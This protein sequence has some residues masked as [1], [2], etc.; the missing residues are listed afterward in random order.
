MEIKSY[1]SQDYTCKYPTQVRLV[2]RYATKA[3]LTHNGA[4]RIHL[5]LNI[6]N[7]NYNTIEQEKERLNIG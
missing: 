6:A 7:C 4:E 5:Q 2:T 3:F 1:F